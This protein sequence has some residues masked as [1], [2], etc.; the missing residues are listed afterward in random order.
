[1]I[2]RNTYCFT[3]I[4]L[5]NLVAHKQSKQVQRSNFSPSVFGQLQQHVFQ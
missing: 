4:L 1:M 3:Y 5:M 2:R